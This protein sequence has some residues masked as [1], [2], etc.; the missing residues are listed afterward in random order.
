MGSLILSLAMA[1]TSSS[2]KPPASRSLSAS[3]TQSPGS[4]ST[5]GRVAGAAY[6]HEDEFADASAAVRD[7]YAAAYSQT[8]GTQLLRRAENNHRSFSA[9]AKNN[10]QITRDLE[11][12]DQ[13]STPE[14]HRKASTA[15]TVKHPYSHHDS[16]SSAPNT[17]RNTQQSFEN[18]SSN[19][20]SQNS[21]H[22]SPAA[23]SNSRR[24]TDTHRQPGWTKQRSPLTKLKVTLD[25]ISK[26]EKRARAEEAETRLREAQA[27]LKAEPLNSHLQ[28]TSTVETAPKPRKVESSSPEEV[29]IQR[30]ADMASRERPQIQDLDAEYSRQNHAT[31]QSNKHPGLLSSA[32]P[33]TKPEPED[34]HLQNLP[35]EKP[36]ASIRDIHS[37]PAISAP[38]VPQ[39]RFSLSKAIGVGRSNSQKLQKPMPKELVAQMHI[40]HQ[41]THDN[42]HRGDD[43]VGLGLSHAGNEAQPDDP[44]QK[45]NGKGKHKQVTVSFA[46]P[47]PTPP[48]LSEWKHAIPCRL[49]TSDFDLR[50]SHVD[51][52]WWETGGSRRRRRSHKIDTEDILPR[53]Q[54]KKNAPFEPKLFLK[55]GPLLR[56]TGI[57]YE[58]VDSR[59]GPIDKEIWRGSIMIVTKDSA[60]SYDKPPSL[61]LF[62]QPMNLLPPPPAVIEATS[63]ELAPEYVDPI[64]GIAKMGRNGK[65]LYVKP[66][67]HI[68]EQ[69]D[70]SFVENEEGLFE[71]SPSPLDYSATNQV[72]QPPD[73]RLQPED[74]ESVGKYKEI[75]GVR[76]YADPGRDVTFWRF[77]IEIELSDGQQRVAYR[78][79]H[80]SAVGFWVPGKGQ[81]MNTM[82]YS[83]NGFSS[84]VDTD[85]CS[86]PDPMWRDVLNV[87]QTRPFHVMIGGG[88]QIC[89]EAVALETEHFQNWLDLRNKFE[90]FEHPLNL[91]IKAELESFY[92]EHYCRWFSQGLFGMANSQIPM[93]NMW[94]GNDIMTGFGSYSDEFMRSPVFSGLGNVAYK[95][96]LLFQHQTVVEE[97]SADE[98]SWLMGLSPGP[99]IRQRSRNI[100]L[101]LGKKV[102]LLAVDCRT[103]RTVRILYAALYRLL[104]I[105]IVEGLYYQRRHVRSYL[106]PL[107]PGD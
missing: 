107:L 9:R 22:A 99:Y 56:F 27:R 100:F 88:G 81:T 55:C 40:S 83:G 101:N 6:P 24:S 48:P 43:H 80:G 5:N 41:T 70:L 73:A 74:G 36:R 39:R 66:V 95:Y 28:S 51:K 84:Y 46:V 19:A 98:P 93:V 87:H 49:R 13:Y 26:E 1:S 47:P 103:E 89:S 102:S 53:R 10:P 45:E 23:P 34:E 92:L 69:L 57:R 58:K 105:P 32:L 31:L 18:S 79:N 59:N 29:K 86:G 65:L 90:Q 33:K 75:E 4:R 60:S 50:D 77:N 96:Y 44:P 3:H 82:F 97:T 8:H 42:P 2:R 30:R 12:S 104:L 94:D 7:G 63:G 64:A 14:F 52:A 54:L 35:V 38:N 71:L 15:T 67:D 61:R 20:Q 11:H 76:L 17:S 78:I 106:G 72:S 21:I 16:P 37:Q 62:S 25:S 91:D 68:E 85:K